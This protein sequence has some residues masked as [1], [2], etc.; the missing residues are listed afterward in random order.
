MVV[1]F[2]HIQNFNHT[3]A[4]VVVLLASIL[5]L[6]ACAYQRPTNLNPPPLHHD[7]PIVPVAD[8]DVLALSPEMEEFLE[9][10]ILIYSNK[11]TS[12]LR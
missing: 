11:H 3:S 1:L 9:R 2:K 12:T 8:V 4:R 10:Y 5:L 6:G 7:G